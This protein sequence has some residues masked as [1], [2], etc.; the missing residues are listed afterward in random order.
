M[1][2][3]AAHVFG[4]SLGRKA[5]NWTNRNGF[6]LRE[7]VNVRLSDLG[8]GPVVN[9]SACRDVKQHFRRV[10]ASQD[11]YAALRPSIGFSGE[12]HDHIRWL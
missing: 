9:D 3:T 1:L 7:L 12:N 8:Q 4:F 6:T 10:S 5:P 11:L 2:Q